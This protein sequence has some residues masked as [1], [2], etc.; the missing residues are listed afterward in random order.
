MPTS[1][2]LFKVDHGQCD[3]HDEN[4]CHDAKNGSQCDFQG[5]FIAD[6]QTSAKK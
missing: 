2:L 3:G 6:Q 1:W 4:D 5:P